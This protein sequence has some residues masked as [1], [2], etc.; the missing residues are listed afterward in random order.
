MKGLAESLR[1]H[2]LT[3]PSVINQF[4]FGHGVVI[5]YINKIIRKKCFHM[6]ICDIAEKKTYFDFTLCEIM[7]AFQNPVYIEIDKPI[8]LKRRKYNFI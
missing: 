6:G 5:Y 1:F 2:L 4:I 7:L 3:N 8:H